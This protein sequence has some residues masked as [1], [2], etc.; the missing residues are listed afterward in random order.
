MVI[1]MEILKPK[2]ATRFLNAPNDWDQTMGECDVLPIIDLTT[3]NGPVMVSQWKPTPKELE[4]LNSNGHIELWIFG[5]AH[6][7]VSLSVNDIRE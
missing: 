3:D 1:K 5:R 4:M 7:V 6:P 2:E